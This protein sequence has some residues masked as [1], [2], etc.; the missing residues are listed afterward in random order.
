MDC[1]ECWM[2]VCVLRVKS[3]THV[4][5]YMCYLFSLQRKLHLFGFPG[6]YRYNTSFL[7]KLLAVHTMYPDIHRQDATNANKEECRGL[8]EETAVCLCNEILCVKLTAT[9]TY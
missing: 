3:C 8:Q 1:C 2:N 7:N 5:L 4:M 9:I 6:D